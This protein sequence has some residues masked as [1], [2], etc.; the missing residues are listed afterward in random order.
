MASGFVNHGKAV[1][2]S[3]HAWEGAAGSSRARN[4]PA[5]QVQRG[6]RAARGGRVHHVQAVTEREVVH[7]ARPTDVG[8]RGSASSTGQILEREQ[9]SLA[10]R[11]GPDIL[12]GAAAEAERTPT[13]CGH[14]PAADCPQSPPGVPNQRTGSEPRTFCQYET[15]WFISSNTRAQHCSQ[16]ELK[17]KRRCA[18]RVVRAGPRKAWHK[19]SRRRWLRSRR[20]HRRTARRPVRIYFPDSSLPRKRSTRRPDSAN[21]LPRGWRTRLP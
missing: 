16:K 7:D 9:S 21:T 10:V 1:A 3:V 14:P 18:C 11:P 13:S 2:P 15:L 4:K 8:Q 12:Q 5:S 6:Q 17:S 19:A 20:G